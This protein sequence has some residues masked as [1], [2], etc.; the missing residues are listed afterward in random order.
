MLTSRRDFRSLYTSKLCAFLPN[1]QRFEV[2]FLCSNRV[3]MQPSYVLIMI[4]F[5]LS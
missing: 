4:R 2:A 1:K 3:K 5:K